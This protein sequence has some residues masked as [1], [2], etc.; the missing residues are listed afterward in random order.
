MRASEASCPAPSAWPPRKGSRAGKTG[1]ITDPL[2]VAGPGPA[3]LRVLVAEDDPGMAAALRSQLLRSGY[4]VAVVP[5]LAEAVSSVIGFAPALAV[6]DLRLVGHQGPERLRLVR[7]GVHLPIVLISPNADEMDR[8]HALD[9][10]A[11]DFVPRPVSPREVAARVRAV[12]RRSAA[13]PGPGSAPAALRAGPLVLDEHRRQAL[14][15]GRNVALTVLESRLLA[16]LMRH[17]GRPV[18]RE[19]LLEE[20]WGYTV[21]DLSTVTVHVRRLREKIE[22]DPAVPSLIRTVWGTGYCF[23]ASGLG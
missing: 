14:V 7:P 21:G 12:L 9:A 2:T 13:P 3:A 23:D 17:P 11:D 19:K 10:G 22:P 20:V 6:L 15:H 8:V 1:R 5:G 16:Y 4:A 18:R